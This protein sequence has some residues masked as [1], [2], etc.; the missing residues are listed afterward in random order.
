MTAVDTEKARVSVLG[1]V[2]VTKDTQGITAQ[3][4]SYETSSIEV[5]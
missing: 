3:Q 4:V 5:F 2:S 1:S